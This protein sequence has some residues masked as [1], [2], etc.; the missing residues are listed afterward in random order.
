MFASCSWA[1]SQ[2]AS[3][4]IAWAIVPVHS[5][6]LPSGRGGRLRCLADEDR[7]RL[8]RRMDR[9]VSTNCTPLV[10]GRMLTHLPVDEVK[11][12]EKWVVDEGALPPPA[13]A[14]LFG[15]LIGA[16]KAGGF[17]QA[18]MQLV[19]MGQAT[20]EAKI[21]ELQEEQK[22]NRAALAELQGPA[23]DGLYL[24]A[25]DLWVRLSKEFASQPDEISDSW[26]NWLQGRPPSPGAQSVLGNDFDEDDNVSVAPSMPSRRHT[27]PTPSSLGRRSIGPAQPGGGYGS[28]SSAG[29]LL[30]KKRASCQLHCPASAFLFTDAKP[31][32]AGGDPAPAR[33]PSQQMIDFVMVDASGKK[34]LTPSIDKTQTATVTAQADEDFATL[35]SRAQTALGVRRGRLVD[36]FGRALDVCT[37]I[38]NSNLQNGASLTLHVK[39]V[40]VCRTERAFAVILGDD[41]V[42]T[43]GD[44][45]YGG[46][47]SAW[48]VQLK[49]VQ[50]M[51]GNHNA[52]VAIRG[53]GYV[54]TWGRPLCGGDSS[55]V[56]LQQV[57]HIQASDHAFAA[58]CRDGSVVTWGDHRCGGDSSAVQDQLRNVQQIQAT[59]GGVASAFGAF[60][61]S[62]GGAFAA[63]TGDGSVVTW[64]HPLFGGDSFAVR[65]RLKNV[66]QIQATNGLTGG[67]FA[68]IRGDGSVV[69]WGDHR[70]GGDSSAVQDQLRNV[71]QIQAFRCSF[72][73][74]L[75]DG[76]A[77]SWGD[78]HGGGDSSAHQL[79]NVQQIQA[80][81][82]A[83]A[84]ILGDGSVLS[85]GDPRFGGDCNAVQAQLVD[86]H[87]IQA[88]G[89]AFAAVLGNGCVVAWG[90]AHH[91]GNSSAVQERLK[92]VQQIQA[93]YGVETGGAF[94]A[95]T[96]DGSV[97]TWG[98]A[99]YGGDGS[100]V[101]E[102]LK[103]VQ[104]TQATNYAFAAIL[105]DGSVVTWGA[106]FFGGDSSAVQT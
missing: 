91:G 57:Q 22:A 9:A 48:Q 17:L 52:F 29:S 106:V 60:G 93:T 32:A 81:D 27:A 8:H 70:Y 50:Q 88:S 75:G 14:R 42:Q 33:R 82:R 97:V 30:A 71:V 105:G 49:N 54:V 102:R 40:R 24:S 83:F 99:S 53:D 25:E 92:N 4:A 101:Q 31:S 104:R 85:W 73:A 96:G 90:D 43:W 84:A 5:A 15:A 59:G 6:Y 68:A 39:Q 61:T 79:K 58:I 86:V 41:S 55:Y 16:Q 28:L 66:Q 7:A 12:I 11:A 87:H 64:G 20:L 100:A 76:S 38:K 51:T 26:S 35:K 98:A 34:T 94:A 95:I 13:A 2:K 78:I 18:V 44:E 89:R 3:R 67:A 56:R 63:I 72:A 103:N 77:V 45:R 21:Q 74:I 80:S 65:K 19:S 46:E 37:R 23:A 36:S 47:T 69:T 62:N 1:W 10:L